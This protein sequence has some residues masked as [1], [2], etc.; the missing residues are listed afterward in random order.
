[1]LRRCSRAALWAS[2]SNE[3]LNKFVR[4]QSGSKKSQTNRIR[5]KIS[6]NFWSSVP[7][8]G[9]TG[10]LARSL[11]I[12]GFPFVFNSSWMSRCPPAAVPRALP[13]RALPCRAVPC[14]A[15][16]RPALPCPALLLWISTRHSVTG[17]RVW[18]AIS[19]QCAARVVVSR[20]TPVVDPHCRRRNE[21]TGRATVVLREECATR[22]GRE[23]SSSLLS[24]RRCHL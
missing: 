5:D 22:A 23:K 6:G 17:Q 21:T 4:D 1:M 20:R 16:P 12:R 13:C 2:R 9:G 15:L 11:A 3:T 24:R 10:R 8:D 14:P 18:R 19:Q 7:H